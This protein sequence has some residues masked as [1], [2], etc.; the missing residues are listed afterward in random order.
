M[1]EN[2]ESKVVIYLEKLLRTKTTVITRW[3]KMK[4]K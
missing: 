4:K 1:E 3:S 2:K